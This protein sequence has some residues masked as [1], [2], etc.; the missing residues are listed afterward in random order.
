[1]TRPPPSPVTGDKYFL[2]SNNS[3]RKV[4]IT[5]E[6]YMTLSP[7]QKFE[8]DLKNKHGGGGGGVGGG[9]DGGGVGGGG[10][11]LI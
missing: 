7:A 3:N 2:G 5:T 8:Q 6:N 4:E 1:M 11:V 9:I 10:V